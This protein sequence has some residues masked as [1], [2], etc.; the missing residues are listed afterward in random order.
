MTAMTVT[1]LF[2]AAL[3]A[4]VLRM[5]RRH[6]RPPADRTAEVFRPPDRTPVRH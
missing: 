5:R 4:L 3:D 1:F 2:S 6:G